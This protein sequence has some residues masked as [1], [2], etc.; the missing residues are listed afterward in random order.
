VRPTAAVPAQ[1]LPL[2][3]PY[4]HPRPLTLLYFAAV[5]PGDRGLV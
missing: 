5:Q 3:A 4:S 2:A 1:H